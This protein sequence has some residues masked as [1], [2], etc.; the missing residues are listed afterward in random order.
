MHED[1]R[2]I[3]AAD[4]AAR[5]DLEALKER[6]A[7]RHEAERA[8]LQAVRDAAG[9]VAAARLESQLQA[10]DA[11]GRVAINARRTARAARGARRRERADG[12]TA[13]AIAA[14]VEVLREEG[15]S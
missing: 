13:S 15:E 1:L 7:A 12:A 2:S 8:R 11:E 6:L 5:R 4:L 10:V 9:A 14:Y 3:V